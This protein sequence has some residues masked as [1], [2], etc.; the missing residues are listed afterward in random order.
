MPK[1]FNFVNSFFSLIKIIL[2]IFLS[3]KKTIFFYFPRKDLTFKDLDFI[4][5][6]FKKIDSNYTIVYGQ[7]IN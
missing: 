3:K 4:H 1:F 5:D 2:K 6:L 7:K